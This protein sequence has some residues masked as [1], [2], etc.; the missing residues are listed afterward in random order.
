MSANESHDLDL[1]KFE[2]QL[3]LSQE[4]E[5]VLDEFV[6]QLQDAFYFAKDAFYFAKG[7][8]PDELVYITLEKTFKEYFKGVDLKIK[9]TGTEKI[10]KLKVGA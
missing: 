3:I 1:A 9:S 4:D 8:L 10:R 6:G 2:K 5:C 7:D